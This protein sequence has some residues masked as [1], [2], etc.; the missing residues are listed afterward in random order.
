VNERQ[1]AELTAGAEGR[2]EGEDAASEGAVLIGRAAAITA[3]IAAAS[4]LVPEHHDASTLPYRHEPLRFIQRD[5]A[6]TRPPYQVLGPVAG[7][8][9][10]APDVVVRER[11][12]GIFAATAAL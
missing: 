7:G 6:A 2:I 11:K 9:Q 12:Q 1:T 3:E 10:E 8:L 4:A 5:L